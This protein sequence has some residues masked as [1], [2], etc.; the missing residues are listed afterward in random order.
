MKTPTPLKRAILV[1]VLVSINLFSSSD[2]LFA[3]TANALNFDG[4][5]DYVDISP[6]IP[7]TS[8]FT[9]ECWIKTSDPNSKFYVWESSVVNGHA[10][11]GMNQGTLRLAS[12]TGVSIDQLDGNT[13]INDDTWHHVAVVKSGNAVTFYVDG[14]SD[15]TGTS[16]ANPFSTITGSA[17]GA[18][19]I[20]NILQGF[21]SMTIDELRIW[22]SARSQTLIQ[23]TMGCDVSV[24]TG[25]VASYHFNQGIG[26]G[27]NPGVTN[28]TDATGNGRNG[29]LLNFALNGTTS[30]FVPSEA[31]PA[32]KIYRT[33]T[34]GNWSSPS[35]WETKVGTCWVQA[36]TSPTITDST[37]TILTGHTVTVNSAVIIDQTEVDP[38]GTL[39]ISSGTL[40]VDD[41]PGSPDLRVRGSMTFSASF[42]EGNGYIE[43]GSAG[44]FTWT[45]GNMRGTGT[46][47]ILPGGTFVLGGVGT[48]ILNDSR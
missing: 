10:Y 44:T 35:V 4:S 47:T 7:Y 6:T 15:G 31:I 25:L 2:K 39:T 13:L 46:T 19:V 16:N 5:D 29:T 43:I 37:I 28:L 48:K 33:I 32:T 21:T 27:S 23:G 40:Q 18:G 11:F 41:G 24:L 1:M 9:I 14:N 34:S 20:N 8:T 26:N 3:Q 36:T 38:G 45:N 17:I 42:I 12:G 30:N 22:N